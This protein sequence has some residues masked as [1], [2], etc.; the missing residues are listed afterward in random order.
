MAKIGFIKDGLTAPPEF[1]RVY[2][3]AVPGL[4]QFSTTAYSSP[5]A[6]GGQS[7]EL[8]CEI[9]P[10]VDRI[11]EWAPHMALTLERMGWMHWWLDSHSIGRALNRYIVEAMKRWG[12][13]F[14]PRYHLESIILVQV[15]IERQEIS[16]AV[17]FWEHQFP[18]VRIAPEF[19][20][21]KRELELAAAPKKSSGLLSSLFKK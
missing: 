8:A 15:G 7:F 6:S 18:H 12:L 3:K 9:P 20:F 10:E 2:V 14:W 5:T 16:K 17:A 11:E 4:K 19:D 13:T 21:D 1:R